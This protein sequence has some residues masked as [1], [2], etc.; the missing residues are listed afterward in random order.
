MNSKIK[1]KLEIT[2]LKGSGPGG[3]NRNKRMSGVRVRHLVTGI[4]VVATER[5]SQKQNLDTALLRLDEK[6]KKHF[7]VPK[8]RKKSIPSKGSVESRLDKKRHVAS[9]KKLRANKTSQWE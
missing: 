1:E 7:S 8:K 3:Q 4:T 2:H 5:R 6:L 9:K